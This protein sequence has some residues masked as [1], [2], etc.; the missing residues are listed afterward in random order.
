MKRGKIGPIMIAPILMGSLVFYILPF[1][2]VIQL[3]FSQGYGRSRAL[4]GLL[5]YRKLFENSMFLL[6]FQNTLRFL[7]IGL[8]LILAVS[9]LLSF[10][11]KSC[12]GRRR[13]MQAALLLPYIMPVA[14][15]V[16]LVQ[17]LFSQEG[18]MNRA[19]Y[20]LGLPVA[21]WLHSAYAF[22]IALGLYLWKNMGYSTLL[23]LAGLAAIP[24]EQYDAAELD[25]ASSVKKFCYITT[26]QM[27]HSLFIATVFSVMNAFK[28]FRE[29]FLI[30]GE[31]PD[32]S[33]YML[34]HFINNSF[35]NLNYSK[36]AV[37][38][39]LFYLLVTVFFGA[40]YLWIER[41]GAA[42]EG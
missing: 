2:L 14:G 12:A 35:Q 26:P 38:S 21:D 13:M 1:F 17:F 6:A 23:L 24:A 5:Q 3:S 11:L 36:L 15:T 19:L 42:K 29:I 34:Q 4:V 37:A 27:W 31:H 7:G 32:E 39:V 41:K 25:G 18:L 33:V 10:L 9:Y 30:G 16:M 40:F 28:C 22:P 8:P 20:T